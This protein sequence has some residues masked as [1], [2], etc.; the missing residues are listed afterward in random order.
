MY[1]VSDHMVMLNLLV[2]QI[3]QRSRYFVNNGC[4]FMIA[5]T[6]SHVFLH[7]S[8]VIIQVWSQR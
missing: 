8:H 3:V 2:E 1:L 5:I 7:R 4:S 6:E